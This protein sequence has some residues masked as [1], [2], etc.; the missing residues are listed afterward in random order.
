MSNNMEDK[1]LIERFLRGDKASFDG[2]V[3]KYQ[4]LVFNLCLKMLGD[5][6]EA[7][8]V[9]QD[10]FL[11][12]YESLRSFRGEAKFSTYL[13]RI[14][15]NFCKNRLKAIIRRRKKI[16]FSIDDPVNTQSGSMQRQLAS[17]DPTP[18]EKMEESEKEGLVI[19][20]LS[21]LSPEYKEIIVLK[22][23]E[24]LKYEEIA[25]ILSIGLGT[26]KSRLSRARSAL[27]EKL[28][29]VL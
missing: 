21:S 14:S 1:E 4:G 28:K 11:K 13:Y 16:A 19:K 23:I 12:V 18:R 29:D 24:G 25:E 7:L 5:Y 26:V 6:Y 10:I 2:L 17:Q 3:S 9:A 22:E 15:I 27:K 8:D 20:A